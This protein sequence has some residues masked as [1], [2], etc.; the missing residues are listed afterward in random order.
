MVDYRVELADWEC[1]HAQ[2]VQLRVAVFVNEQG[3]P[4]ELEVDEFDTD[5]LHV[6]ALDI[7]DRFIG[8]ARLL[9][10]GYIG[11]MCVHRDYRHLGVGSRMLER[12]LT[13]ARKRGY[14]KLML[15]AQLSALPFYHRFGFEADSDIFIEA[16]I[17]HQ[18]MTLNL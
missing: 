8:T 13:E 15:H 7:D 9:P 2:L 1:D 14:K 18:H 6:K 11:R 3:V 17:D 5:C 4:E 16:G 12:L 10:A